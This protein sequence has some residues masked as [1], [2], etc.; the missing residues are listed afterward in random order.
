[1]N[2][3]YR[4]THYSFQRNEKSLGKGENGGI[5][6]I[7]TEPHIEYQV[8]AKFFESDKGDKGKVQINEVLSN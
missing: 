2:K 6:D 8:V 1:M 3:V 7:I 5:Y 4:G